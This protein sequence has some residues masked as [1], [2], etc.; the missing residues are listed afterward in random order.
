[1]DALLKQV[2]VMQSASNAITQH[3]SK[4]KFRMLMKRLQETVDDLQ[5]ENSMLRRQISDSRA[6]Q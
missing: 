5:H 3:E 1:M 2:D 6:L 4:L